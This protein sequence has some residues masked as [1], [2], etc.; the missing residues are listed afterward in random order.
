[1]DCADLGAQEEFWAGTLRLE[2]EAGEDALD[3]RLRDSTI[4]FRRA[5]P[6]TAP[7]HHFA[8]NVPPGSIERAAAWI[9]ER[10][11]LLAFHGDPDEEEGA[12]I[13][14]TDRGTPAV[15]FLDPAGNVVELIAN[16]R[17]AGGADADVR[18]G[19]PLGVGIGGSGEDATF[20][21]EALLD[22]A[23]V[24][25]AAVDCGATCAAVRDFLGEGVLW[26]GAPGWQ[27][28]AIGDARAV[29]IVAPLDRGWIPVGLPARPV[30]TEI[31]VLTA[32]PAELTLPEGP[33]V[34]RR[35]T[36]PSAA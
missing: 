24:G 2:V 32:E 28:T 15:Y 10:H 33:Y 18:P 19:G 27:L 14:H 4:R 12:T 6:G 13:V 16:V 36:S 8:I 31:V 29:V 26:G 9:R 23:E 21:P 30:P 25:I 17:L 20:G 7:R 34:L 11:E 5:A 22:L 1:M 35:V 3:V